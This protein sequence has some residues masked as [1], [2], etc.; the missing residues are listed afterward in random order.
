MPAIDAN[1]AMPAF[2]S[3]TSARPDD[4]RSPPPDPFDR[5]ADEQHE[6]VHPDD[7]DADDRED[8]PLRVVMPDG[9]VAREVHHAGHHRE[10]AT[11]ATIAVATP[12]RRRISRERP[13]AVGAT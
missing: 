1:H 3:A 5:V 13:R 2:E 8:A 11:A 4:H 7:V 10:A 9:D 12:G 6:P